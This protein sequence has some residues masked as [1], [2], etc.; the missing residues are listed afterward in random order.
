MPTGEEG[1]RRIRECELGDPALMLRA[2]RISF[3]SAKR[4]V[5]TRPKL[6]TGTVHALKTIH[7][8]FFRDVFTFAGKLRD[9]NISKGGFA[10]ADCSYFKDSLPLV[11]SLPEKS[12]AN[13]VRKYI[14]MNII[15][16]FREG[17]GRSMRFWLDD[18]LEK[19]TGYRVDWTRIGKNE[20]LSAMIASHED[21][22]P[23]VDLVHRALTGG[24]DEETI[25]R[26]LRQSWAY[27]M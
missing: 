22:R 18:M 13:I 1:F 9:C 4:F 20:Y 6:R 26:G 17:N 7:L 24:N 2:D 11:E 19:K 10:F 8:H 3:E 12:F 25:I 15:H 5:E 27:E 14:R 21:E 23:I 16:P